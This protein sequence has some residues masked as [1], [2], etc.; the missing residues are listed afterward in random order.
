MPLLLSL[1]LLIS[2]CSASSQ[3]FSIDYGA[4]VGRD[5]KV[6][7]ENIPLNNLNNINQFHNPVKQSYLSSKTQKEDFDF[8][9]DGKSLIEEIEE[10]G[11]IH[12]M[13]GV[14]KKG[15]RV[16]KIENKCVAK[17]ARAFHLFDLK[18]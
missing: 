13:D 15:T 8:L 2:N 18:W 11:D 14:F 1:L 6:T 3:D 16:Y 5:S 7:K 10:Q 4:V 17:F 9:T 12:K